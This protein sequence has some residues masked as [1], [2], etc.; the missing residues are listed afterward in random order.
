[1]LDLEF[2]WCSC[3]ISMLNFTYHLSPVHILTMYLPILAYLEDIAINAPKCDYVHSSCTHYRPIEDPNM[4][5]LAPLRCAFNLYHKVQEFILP[6]TGLPT[7]RV[8]RRFGL[9]PVGDAGILDR[10]VGRGR[11]YYIDRWANGGHII[12]LGGSVVI[13]S[14]HR[15]R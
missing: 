12:E 4:P 5:Y 13:K 8:W 9:Y 1:V 7:S 10:W 2:I 15:H 3:I 14:I 11:V 6:V